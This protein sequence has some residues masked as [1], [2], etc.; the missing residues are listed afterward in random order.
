MPGIPKIN[1]CAIENQVLHQE[2]RI[3]DRKIKPK[4]DIRLK[5]NLDDNDVAF[6]TS[7]GIFI[8]IKWIF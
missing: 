5:L 1:Q 2:L 7:G 8:I 3:H 6:I 4:G